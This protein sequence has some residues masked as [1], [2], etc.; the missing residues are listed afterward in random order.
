M[1]SLLTHFEVL[2][3]T[4]HSTQMNFAGDTKYITLVFKCEFLDNLGSTK[5]QGRAKVI[6]RGHL[7][8]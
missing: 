8:A 2:L 1:T 3:G 5:A 6:P 4:L 7:T